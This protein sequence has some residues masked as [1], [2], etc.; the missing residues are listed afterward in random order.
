MTSTPTEVDEGVD[1]TS[2]P[3]EADE[4]VDPGVAGPWPHRR[5]GI[6]A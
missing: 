4:G 3:S 6:A 2:T 5:S 1:P